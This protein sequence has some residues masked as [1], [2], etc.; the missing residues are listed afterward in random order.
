M[1]ILRKELNALYASQNLSHEV[2]PE[3]DLENSKEKASII[4]TV[5]NSCTVIT[6][7]TDH[8]IE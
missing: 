8:R 7:D 1:D 4:A 2:L 5:N 3:N 6:D